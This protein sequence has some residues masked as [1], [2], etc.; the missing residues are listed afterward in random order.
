MTTGVQD[1][2]LH[3][4]RR[5]GRDGSCHTERASFLAFCGQYRLPPTADA[6][7]LYLVHL[8]DVRP[9]TIAALRYRLR[10]LDLAAALAGE[11]PPSR[12]ASLRLFLRGLH[13]TLTSDTE[14]NRTPLYLEDVD[15]LL[16]AIDRDRT[17]QLRDT[18]FVLL[19][20]ACALPMDVLR[21]LQWH[22]VRFRR[23]ELTLTLPQQKWARGPRGRVVV[24]A[25]PGPT[26]PIEAMRAWSRHVG[27]A[28]GYVFATRRRRP[29]GMKRAAE[30]LAPLVRS[31]DT[32][33]HRS[34]STPEDVLL[35][36][37][38]ELGAPRPRELRDRAVIT[39]AFAACL[40]TEEARNLR[41]G[42]VRTAPQGLL[43]HPPGRAQPA[44]VPRGRVPSRCPVRHWAAWRNA[45][46]QRGA[47]DE[48]LTFPQIQEQCI[49]QKSLDGIGP[50]W[51]V[52]SR[53]EQ[54]GLHGDFG[55]TSLRI[56]FIRTAA[57]AGIPE[58]LIL[59]QAGLRRLD[60]VA[61]HVRREQLMSH[62]AAG[63]V[64]L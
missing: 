24:A 51:L 10:L 12:D 2:W 42:H 52:T 62:N 11:Q 40:T 49:S 27:P 5:T 61:L 63:M 43:V 34:P 25:R 47:T 26:C 28:N 16:H 38:A 48:D 9:R 55:F 20:D 17:H 18:A 54:A 14:R 33:G 29:P 39:L 53:C 32:A 31:V 30:L 15:A 36:Y 57:R 4:E 7:A 19:A 60:S 41:L 8:H 64:G 50:A 59:Q 23:N 37:L 58:Q 44:G 22:Q 3:W 46:E 21:Q 35:P 1:S 45:L 56:G 6:V 13:R